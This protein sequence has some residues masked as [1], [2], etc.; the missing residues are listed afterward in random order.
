MT[1]YTAIT[2]AS[3]DQ[4]SPLT[5]D[6][7]TLLRNN[8]IAMAEG[9]A[10]APVVAAGWHPYD[11][12]AVGDGGDGEFYDFATDGASASIETPTFANGYEY[13]IRFDDL[14]FTA[15]GNLTIE[16]YHAATAAW[17]TMATHAITGPAGYRGI[18]HIKYPRLVSHGHAGEWIAPLSAT[19]ASL[20]GT[21]L[22]TAA[23]VG[24]TPSAISKARVSCS[25]F[26][27]DAGKM[28]LLRRREY[29]T[30]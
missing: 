11:M 20:A 8:P 30:G 24:A 6:L 25:T 18:F 16:V 5:T 9:S 26:N 23:V 7:V 12:T 27:T 14:S 10:D 29:I 17:A 28:Q 19:G 22:A 1:T 15:N 21:G 2:N 13:A 4:D 3:I